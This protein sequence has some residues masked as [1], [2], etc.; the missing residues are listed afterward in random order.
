MY[1]YARAEEI[2]SQIFMILNQLLVG[3]ALPLRLRLRQKAANVAQDDSYSYGL[4]FRDRTLGFVIQ[5]L[6][7][8]V[9]FGNLARPYLGDIGIGGALNAFNGGGFGRVTLLHQFLRALGIRER[10]IVDLLNIA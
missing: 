8:N 9:I 5:I 1:L 10:R 6:L 2:F 4:N 7:W 3:A